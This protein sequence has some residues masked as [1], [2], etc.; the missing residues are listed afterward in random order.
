M[1]KK[2]FY[3]LL[4]YII[5]ILLGACRKSD[6]QV[7]E[8][9][10]MHESGEGIGTVTWTNDKEYVLDGLVFVNDGQVL[11]IEAGTVI[12]ARTGQG[13]DASALIVARGG[14][15]IAEG[16]PDQPIVFTVEGDDLDGSVPIYSRGLWGGVMILG[17]APLNTA[18]G[19]AM[20]EGIPLIEPRGVYGG[21][22]AEDNSGI[23]KYV[24]IRHGGTR[25]GEEN[26]ING[27]TLAGVGRG[28][29]I[30]HVEVISNADDGVEF[31]GGTVDCRYLVAAFCTDDAFDF[32]Q[33][34]QGRGQFWLGLQEPSTGDYL[35]EHDGGTFPMNA[36]PYSIPTLYNV[37]YIGQGDY[38][39]KAL[40]GFMDNGGGKYYNSLFVNQANGIEIEYL[41]NDADSYQ[42]W[43]NHNLVIEHNVFFNVAD[44]QGLD[45]FTLT[46]HDAP[47]SIQQ[48]L[49]AYFDSAN[50]K[51]VD[52]E[53]PGGELFGIIPGKNLTDS[54]ATYPGEWFMPVD[55]K[56]AFNG[57]NWLKG[58]SLLEQRGLVE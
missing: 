57:D 56:G 32:D 46:G 40:M 16:S 17:N 6:Y 43:K 54:V 10:I 34:Y 18:T 1:A 52:P 26:E 4:I 7:P 37:T 11:T 30:E 8:S 15:I 2:S 21:N 49:D 47:A 9:S 25:L 39:G 31:F 29:T 36:R 12:K 58:W 22:D 33:G 3:F 48:S 51:L 27:L 44:N 14:K 45:V 23:L 50:N 42:Q 41:A 28:T 53:L 38:F 24:S 55:Y 35:A 5:F 20:I 13:E 19:E